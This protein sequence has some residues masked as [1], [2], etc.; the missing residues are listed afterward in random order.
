MNHNP[1]ELPYIWIPLS[2][3]QSSYNCDLAICVATTCNIRT[4]FSK[5][6]PPWKP[7]Y[8]PVKVVKSKR[9]ISLEYSR[10]YDSDKLS[11]SDSATLCVMTV[12]P[13]LLFFFSFPSPPSPYYGPLPCLADCAPSLLSITCFTLALTVLHTR[14]S[15]PVD[16][17]LLCTFHA[18]ISS[19][20]PYVSS[21]PLC[22]SPYPPNMCSTTPLI[23]ILVV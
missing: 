6:W 4:H 21:H 22:T 5:Q 18:H 20:L 14:A 7:I 9:N 12:R 15:V 19:P 2:P 17:H 10:T 8:P 11:T 23:R 1:R 3:E 16:V 13:G